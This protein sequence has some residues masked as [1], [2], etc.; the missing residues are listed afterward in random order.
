MV[1]APLSVRSQREPALTASVA[2]HGQHLLHEAL[3]L[4]LPFSPAD[5]LATGAE[6]E[7]TGV[8]LASPAAAACPTAPIPRAPAAHSLAHSIAAVRRLLQHDPFRLRGHRHPPWTTDHTHSHTRSQAHTCTAHLLAHLLFNGM[9]ER[10]LKKFK[11]SKFKCKIPSRC[12]KFKLV[13]GV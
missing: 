3:H 13:G 8:L 12:V 5:T 10:N 4:V 11:P 6:Q 9:Q 1:P 7:H 2:H